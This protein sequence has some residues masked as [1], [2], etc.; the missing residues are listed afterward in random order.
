MDEQRLLDAKT[1]ARIMA[2]SEK[3]LWKRTKE[4]V[5]PHIRIGNRVLYSIVQLDQWIQ[6]QTQPPHQPISD[7][8]EGNEIIEGPLEQ[9]LS[10]DEWD[11]SA[12]P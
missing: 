6:E 10:T 7:Y 3:T 5:I 12:I 8:Q 4:G 11:S 2:I 9:F 1:T